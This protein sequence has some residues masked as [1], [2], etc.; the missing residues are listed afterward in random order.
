MKTRPSVYDF[1]AF[2]A[3]P[4]IC[5]GMNMALLETKMFIAVMVNNFRAQI[6]DGE[7]LEDRGYA[8]SPTLTLKDGLPLQMTPRQVACAF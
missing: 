5:I 1:P 4:R 3:G 6:Q 7:Q 8:I 2:Q